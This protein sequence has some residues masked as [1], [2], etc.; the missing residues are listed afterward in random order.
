[1]AERDPNANRKLHFGFAT[2][3]FRDASGERSG[4]LKMR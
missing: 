4:Y 3:R 2:L 1:M